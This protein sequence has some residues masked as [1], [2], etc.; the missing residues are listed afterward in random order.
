MKAVAVN[1]RLFYPPA[2]TKS[3]I[4]RAAPASI[5]IYTYFSPVFS[6]SA[7]K[8]ILSITLVSRSCS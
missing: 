8:E 2:I 1:H 6:R 5:G 7:A 4:K 3:I